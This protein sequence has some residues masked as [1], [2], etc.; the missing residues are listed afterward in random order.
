MENCLIIFYHFRTLSLW[1]DSTSSN[2]FALNI[3]SDSICFHFERSLFLYCPA[4]LSLPQPSATANNGSDIHYRSGFIFR[5]F[6]SFSFRQ[7][8]FF[9]AALICMYRILPSNIHHYFLYIHI[10]YTYYNYPYAV[11]LFIHII[12]WYPFI[13]DWN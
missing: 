4:S 10:M 7:L 5:F 2:S 11:R 9:S 1:W 12:T 8:G 3:C 13:W 6:S